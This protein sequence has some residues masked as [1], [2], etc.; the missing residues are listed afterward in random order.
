MGNENSTLGLS[1]ETKAELKRDTEQ[2]KQSEENQQPEI[3]QAEERQRAQVETE[4]NQREEAYFAIQLAEKARLEAIDKASKANSQQKTRGRAKKTPTGT[5]VK[6]KFDAD[7]LVEEAAEAATLANTVLQKDAVSTGKD[8]AQNLEVVEK[9]RLAAEKAAAVKKRTE[10]QAK[11]K[12]RFNSMQK[13]KSLQNAVEQPLGSQGSEEGE[14]REIIPRSGT[15]LAFRGAASSASTQYSRDVS[16]R[17]RPSSPSSALHGWNA[18]KQPEAK[19]SSKQG[20]PPSS[21]SN[22][23]VRRRDSKELVSEPETQV[24]RKVPPSA[25]QSSTSMSIDNTNASA[26]AST[27]QDLAI[28]PTRPPVAQKRSSICEVQ[29]SPNLP[30]KPLDPHR[31][32]STSTALD[33]STLPP[34]PAASH[35][36]SIPSGGF[37]ISK[38]AKIPKKN[39]Q[40]V[41]SSASPQSPVQDDEEE[42]GHLLDVGEPSWGGDRQPPKWYGRL[43]A[44]TKRDAGHGNVQVLLERL[45]EK[46]GKIKKLSR[47][48]GTER[49]LNELREMIHKVFFIEVTPQLLRNLRML[50]NN[51]GL[52]QIFD[53]RYDDKVPWPYDVKADAEELYNKWCA[54]TFEID[55]LR[56]IKVGKPK[57]AKDKGSSDRLDPKFP[58][59]PSNYYG[60]GRLLNGQWWP[61]QLTALRDGAHGSSQGGIYGETGQGAYS[62][63][64][65]GGVDKAGNKYPDVD[66]G[67]H[68]QYCGT[69]NDGPEK[70]PSDGTQRL[71][72]SYRLKTPIRLIRSSNAD[73]VYAPEEG[74][75]YDGLYEITGVE[76]IDAADSKRQ[77]HRFTLQRKPGQDPIRSSGPAK[78]PTQQELDAYKK[79]KTLRGYGAKG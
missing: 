73:P 65:S 33:V 22:D 79:D 18:R 77:R 5:T 61:T 49:E 51:D 66:E 75:R 11:L 31:R 6:Q 58:K 64:M 47:D 38:M 29:D 14:I 74:F 50:H 19:S 43:K 45:K 10:E 60:N 69:D 21:S 52:P 63:I 28:W 20:G 1:E 2:L 67:D 27:G 34:K 26:K 70:K 17:S 57:T 56:G 44:I 23:T 36:R 53:H 59:V 71:I 15:P 42:S 78:R 12:Q 30:P 62:V 55:L 72:E 35:K 76:H 13:Q 54:R 7:R 3:A 40:A 48:A 46:I 8:A 9:E 68:V 25:T 32:S 39:H 41:S 24:A 37:D 4:R 16:D